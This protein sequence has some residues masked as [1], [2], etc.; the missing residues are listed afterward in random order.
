MAKRQLLIESTSKPTRT[1]GGKFRAV[2]ITPGQGSSG[3][4]SEA[5]LKRDGAIAFPP[6][7]K[8]WINHPTEDHPSRDPRDLFGIYP[9]GAT[10]EEGVGL[11]GEFVPMPHYREFAEAVAPHA[12]LSIY[13]MGE[14]D[15]DGNVTALL[16]DVQNSVDLVGYPGRPGSGLSQMYESARAAALTE[17]TATSADEKKETKMTPEERKAL[18]EELTASLGA[19]LVT[20]SKKLAESKKEGSEEKGGKNAVSEARKAAVAALNAVHEAELPEA[21]RKN[22]VAAVED[23]VTDVAPLIENAK[24]LHES[25]KKELAESG[26]DTRGHVLGE[27]RHAESDDAVLADWKLLVG[28]AK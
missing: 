22:L 18:I 23:G 16:P 12:A 25:V 27:S 7:T 17:R 15:L 24:A 3:T 11:V 10:Y 2:L 28:G 9:E 14:S 13:A 21:L 19:F 5:L 6:G 4:Y 26:A 1:E 8:S 20:E